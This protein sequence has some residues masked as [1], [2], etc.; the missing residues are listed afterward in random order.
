MHGSIVLPP[1]S[2]RVAVVA[3]DA[4]KYIHQ[5]QNKE[6]QSSVLYIGTERTEQLS[7]YDIHHTYIGIFYFFLARPPESSPDIPK[8]V[9]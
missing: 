1:I 2:R 7:T 5:V 9:E 6:E 4:K 8:T 3:R